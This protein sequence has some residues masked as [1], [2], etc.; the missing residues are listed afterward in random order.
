LSRPC[1]GTAASRSPRLIACNATHRFPEVHVAASQAHPSSSSTLCGKAASVL[2]PQLPVHLPRPQPTGNGLKVASI[3]SAGLDSRGEC[4]RSAATT[5]STAV[6]DKSIGHA[7]A[8]RCP[9]QLIDASVG[10]QRR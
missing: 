2:L 6:A 1:H 10:E 5:H 8:G 4:V 9:L 7:Q 3:R